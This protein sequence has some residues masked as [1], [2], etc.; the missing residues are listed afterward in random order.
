MG[1]WF[2]HGKVELR[3]DTIEG[4]ERKI[5]LYL[6]KSREFVDRTTKAISQ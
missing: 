6:K 1:K 2:S 4:E 3:F 5:W